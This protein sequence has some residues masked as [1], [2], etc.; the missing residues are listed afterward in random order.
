MSE[1]QG[2]RIPPS[3]VPKLIALLSDRYINGYATQQIEI[4]AVI[5]DVRTMEKLLKELLHSK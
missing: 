5:E 1:N 4:L 3:V 2:L